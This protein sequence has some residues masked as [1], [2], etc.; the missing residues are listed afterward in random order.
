MDYVDVCALDA[1]APGRAVAV[2]VEDRDV[3]LFNVDGCVHALED[4]CLHQGASLAAGKFCGRSVTCRA[5]GW[6]YDVTTGA[7]A[8]SPTLG[9]A[10]F[11]V[12]VVAGRVLVALAA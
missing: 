1:V 3:A 10:S 11:P 12:K 8:A 5:H 6:R 4:S 7:L 2:R 9:V